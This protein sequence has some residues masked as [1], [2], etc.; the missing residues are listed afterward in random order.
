M[1]TYLVRDYMG[2]NL[3]DT[4]IRGA[5]KPVLSLF[6]A[7][8]LTRGRFFC[9]VFAVFSEDSNYQDQSEVIV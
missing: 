5:E 4:K 7:C 6:F 9:Q 8:N 3:G 1:D 2:D